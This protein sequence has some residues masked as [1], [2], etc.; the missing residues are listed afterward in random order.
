MTWYNFDWKWTARVISENS[1][2]IAMA[3]KEYHEALPSSYLALV[4]WDEN[5]ENLVPPSTAP[6]SLFGEQE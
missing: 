4:E 2:S 3:Y 6:R 5:A 1:D